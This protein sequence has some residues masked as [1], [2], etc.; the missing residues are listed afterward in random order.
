M[1]LLTMSL[2]TKTDVSLTIFTFIS[3][4]R[5]NISAEMSTALQVCV[6]SP[7]AH[8]PTASM[9]QS[10]RRKVRCSHIDEVVF[11]LIFFCLID[12]EMYEYRT[13][14]NI[15]RQAE[16]RAAAGRSRHKTYG[17]IQYQGSYFPTRRE[18]RENACFF[19]HTCYWKNSDW[20]FVRSNAGYTCSC[21][22]I[23]ENK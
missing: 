18:N 23:H 5:K 16:R 2:K 22:L 9:P 17:V 21:D 4:R 12:I 19:C 7:T 20:I 13:S 15:E 10:E 14:S 8:L 6:I 11:V 3:E 1:T